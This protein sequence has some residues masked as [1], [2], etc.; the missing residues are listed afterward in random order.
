VNVNDIDELRRLQEYADTEHQQ[1]CLAALIQHD[2]VRRHA[3]ASLG[4]LE[5]NLR[6]VI[7]KLR[8]RAAQAGDA[9]QLVSQPGHAPHGYSVRGYSVHK[10][11][12][13]ETG[14]V[15]VT[16]W[17]EKSNRDDE[18]RV[19][20]LRALAEELAENVA[21][22]YR[23]W[24]VSELELSHEAERLNVYPM[25]DPHIGAYAWAKESGADFD[26]ERAEADLVRATQ[27]LVED[28]PTAGTALVVSLGDFFHSETKSNTTSQSGHPLDVDSRYSRVMRIGVHAFVACIDQALRRH[29]T[30][31]VLCVLGNHDWHA[32]QWLEMI[33]EAHFRDEPRVK[34]IRTNGR[35]YVYWRW[36]ETLFG[37]TH[38]DKLKIHQLSGIMPRDEPVMW[39]QT[40]HR[41]WL[42]GHIHTRN[43]IELQDGSVARSYRTL[44]ARDAWHASEGYHAGRDM[45]RETYHVRWGERGSDRAPVE[46]IHELLESERA[47]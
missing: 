47:K 22:K 24:A 8:K 9:G 29:A 15:K 28:S 3:A 44:A 27:T 18:A 33:V 12:D 41:R 36:G 37:F 14:A 39:G 30:V 31:Y 25:G 23:P 38:G 6:K 4:I 45:R 20:A 34:I 17:W 19:E 13:P 11:V 21:G 5:S 43:E 2:G 46:M 35:H 42:T 32:S 26:C 10:H 7:R 1:R 16:N 40:R